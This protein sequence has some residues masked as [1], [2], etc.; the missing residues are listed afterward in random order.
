VLFVQSGA[1]RGLGNT[2]FPLR[3]NTTGIWAAV[4]L[5]F[6]LIQTIG[7]SLALVWACFLITAPVTAF[8]LW[9]RFRREI[10]SPSMPLPPA[11]SLSASVAAGQNQ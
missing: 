6:A 4:V 1:L 2:R 7:G 11:S 9:W 8:L 10:K 5:A 3:V